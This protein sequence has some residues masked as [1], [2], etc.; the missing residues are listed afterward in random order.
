V[1]KEK[2]P[3][4]F[5]TNR[6]R[7]SGDGYFGERFHSD[8]PSF[9][10]CG[11]ALVEFD[12]DA[13][14]YTLISSGLEAE[15]KPADPSGRGARLGST[16]MFRQIRDTMAAEEREALVLI[17]GFGNSFVGSL[18]RGAQLSR[19]YRI[20]RVPE[21]PGGPE[22]APQSPIVVVFSWPSNGRVQPP[23]EYHSDRED[24]QQSGDA[25][26]RFFMRF[27]DFLNDPGKRGTDA[28]GRPLP[29]GRPIHLVAH[30]MGNWALR[31]AVQSIKRMMAGRAVP[32]VFDNVFLMAADADEDAL[33][34]EEKLYP[35]IEMARAIHV[36][37]ASNDRALVVSDTTKFNPD[38]LGTDGPHSFARLPPHVTA[39]D[40]ADVSYTELADARHQYYSSRQE[41]LD[42]VRAVLTG[43]YAPDQVPRRIAIDPG[44]RYR[45]PRAT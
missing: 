16:A 9:Y 2:I 33:A 12:S 21:A 24:S 22:P 31:A 40:C 39:I 25:M 41:V 29:C 35:M 43:R 3:V 27:W 4:F 30:S 7:V 32:K 38:R 14:E 13:D 26:A 18:L 6:N 45:I 34:Q 36:Y 42:D 44:R 20:A 23:W 15:R 5:A 10:R 11:Q 19:E 1:A 37:H 28:D 8:G 17:H